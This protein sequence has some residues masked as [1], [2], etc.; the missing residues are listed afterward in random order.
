MN[1]HFKPISISAKTKEKLEFLSEKSSIPQAKLLENYIDCMFAVAMYFERF[2]LSFDYDF[3]EGT[4]TTYLTGRRSKENT[5]MFGTSKTE[6]DMTNTIYAKI[7]EDLKK[8]AM[9]IDI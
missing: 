5:I 2:G 8:K 7:N 4:V 6:Q 1:E 3:S 9:G